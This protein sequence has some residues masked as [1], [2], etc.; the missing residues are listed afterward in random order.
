MFRNRTIRTATGPSAKLLV[1]NERKYSQA[2]TTPAAVSFERPISGFVAVRT[3]GNGTGGATIRRSHALAVGAA[4]V[5]GG[6]GAAGDVVDVVGIG[7]REALFVRV[8][9]EGHRVG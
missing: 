4:L 6:V 7:E 5:W 3:H 2:A 1:D 9:V 8:A